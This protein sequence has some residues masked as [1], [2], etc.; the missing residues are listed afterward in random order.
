MIINSNF[1]WMLIKWLLFI[2]K[3]K[4]QSKNK[5]LDHPYVWDLLK[6]SE[7]PGMPLKKKKKYKTTTHKRKVPSST[8]LVISLCKPQETISDYLICMSDRLSTAF[9]FTRCTEMKNSQAG[10]FVS[11]YIH[12]MEVPWR[13]S[14]QEGSNYVFQQNW[15]LK[16][17]V[18][19]GTLHSSPVYVCSPIAGRACLELSFLNRYHLRPFV[20]FLR[21]NQQVCLRSSLWSLRR[22]PIFGVHRTAWWKH[23]VPNH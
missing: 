7:N 23:R 6:V 19:G 1:Q 4:S 3:N 16:L 20:L 14:V 9:T 18:R 21:V 17:L 2:L 13:S 8:P 15:C 12:I 5:T 11:S 22:R 10:C